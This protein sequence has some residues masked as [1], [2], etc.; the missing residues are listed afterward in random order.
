MELSRQ[1]WRIVPQLC[2]FHPSQAIYALCTELYKGQRTRQLFHL[3][4][5]CVNLFPI[6]VILRAFSAIAFSNSLTHN[7]C[8]H[9][10]VLLAKCIYVQYHWVKEQNKNAPSGMD[11]QQTM[12]VRMI[13]P[14]LYQSDCSR[15]IFTK[16]EI[17]CN[18]RNLYIAELHI[19]YI[20]LYCWI[21]L[22][23]CRL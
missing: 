16:Q 4:L 3:E 21:H 10:N 12:L 9:A 22:P 13:S 2:T 5:Q 23:G 18:M 19:S 11:Y 20:S 14:Q 6:C 1:Y 17:K 8:V 7:D 15:C